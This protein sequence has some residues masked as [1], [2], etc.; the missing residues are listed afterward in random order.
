MKTNE[1]IELLARQTPVEPRGRADRRLGAALA[2]GGSI[3]LGFVVL[4][5]RCQPLLVAGAQPWFW[6]KAAFTALLTAVGM[7]MVRRLASPGA[8]AR[9]AP[10]LGVAVIVAIGSLGIGQLLS[11]PSA[12][13][14]TV[15]LGQTWKLCALLILLLALPIYVALVF[16]V[17]TL[18]PTRLRLS[19]AAAGFS[20]GAFAAT[21]YGLHCP[22]QAAA[23]VMTWYSLG[24][25]ASAAMG[26]LTGPRLLRW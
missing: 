19:G 3:S 14:M 20:A 6:M 17:R 10:W 23:F 1:L 4:W 11:T 16:A 8:A 18:A 26:A 21:L 25:A 5:L 12:L 2:L 15:W 22:E 13:R 7:A 9:V 24:I